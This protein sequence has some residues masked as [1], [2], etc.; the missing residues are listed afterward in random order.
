MSAALLLGDPQGTRPRSKHRPS[1]GCMRKASAYGQATGQGSVEPRV[2]LT[3]PYVCVLVIV[4]VTVSPA[5]DPVNRA[6]VGAFDCGGGPTM[7]VN[8]PSAVKSPRSF[9]KGR[10]KEPRPQPAATS[11]DDA[12]TSRHICV[13]AQWPSARRRAIGGSVGLSIRSHEAAGK[14][15]SSVSIGILDFLKS[16]GLPQN[17]LTSVTNVFAA[18]ATP[19]MIIVIRAYM[20]KGNLRG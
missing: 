15:A 18:T 11:T 6:D 1:F 9:T 14:S 17:H 3:V 5:T 19:V 10:G 2:A 7:T 16:I 8:V 4:T 12:L 20:R 13:L